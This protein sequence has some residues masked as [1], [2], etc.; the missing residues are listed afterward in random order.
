MGDTT[1]MT[2]M[3]K[4]SDAVTDDVKREIGSILSNYSPGYGTP[5][6]SEHD[7]F[8][9]WSFS[10]VSVGEQDQV[11]G[12][13]DGLIEHGYTDLNGKVDENGLDFQHDVSDFAYK[14]WTD[15]KYEYPGSLVWHI[16]GL[17]NFDA[18][19][20][21]NGNPTPSAR[22]LEEATLNA[23]SLAQAQGAVLRLTGGAHAKVWQA[24]EPEQVEYRVELMRTEYAHVI[25]RASSPQ[26]ASE[27]ALG[28]DGEGLTFQPIDGWESRVY[29]NADH[30][31]ELY[32]DE[33]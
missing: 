31:T 13:I 19:C 21:A 18:D 33:S 17:P 3:V 29:D 23:E 12:D 28:M 16:P 11:A 5:E 27:R 9:R 6:P 2:V 24:R 25:V 8:L 22:S 32:R 1:A 14:V 7:G 10:D 26:E 15:P 20:D 30:N 4:V